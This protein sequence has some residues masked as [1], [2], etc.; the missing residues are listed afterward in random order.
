MAKNDDFITWAIAGGIA[1]LAA[2]FGYKALTGQQSTQTNTGVNV[3][4][5]ATGCSKCPFS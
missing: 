2:V 3:S 1:L 5:H 4:N